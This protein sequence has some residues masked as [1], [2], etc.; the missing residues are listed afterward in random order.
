[1][2]LLKFIYKWFK[3][4][5]GRRSVELKLRR[6]QNVEQKGKQRM[7]IQRVRLWRFLQ[8]NVLWRSLRRRFLQWNVLW[9]SLQWKVLWRS[10]QRKVPRLPLQRK[11]L[12]RSIA[13]IELGQLRKVCRNSKQWKVQSFSPCL[14]W[15][16]LTWSDSSII[17]FSCLKL[18]KSIDIVIIEFVWM[19]EG[20]CQCTVLKN[21]QSVSS[22]LWLRSF[23]VKAPVDQR[24]S[25]GVVLYHRSFY[26]G[27][28]CHPL[29]SCAVDYGIDVIPL[30]C[31]CCK[32]N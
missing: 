20:K 11:L 12:W 28:A 27:K 3:L 24:P 18:S 13:L 30:F 32:Q 16:S 23:T 1:M 5:H 7:P 26:V 10:L 25:I 29:P 8:R 31:M 17:K 6:K 14:H 4:F 2:S 19:C 21:F 22:Q 9:R 15:K